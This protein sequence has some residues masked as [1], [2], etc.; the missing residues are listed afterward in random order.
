MADFPR[1]P[2][3]Q[4]LHFGPWGLTGAISRELSEKF[5]R[6]E[7]GA[8]QFADSVPVSVCSQ[9]ERLKSLYLAGLFSYPSFTHAEREAHRI[10]EVALKLRF[11]EHYGNRVPL[12]RKDQERTITVTSFDDVRSLVARRRERLAGHAEFDG[13]LASLLRWARAEGY[14]YGQHNRIRERITSHLRNVLQHSEADHISALPD[15]LRT[16]TLHFQ[17][18]QR[19]WGCDTPGGDAYPGPVPRT[20]WVI[21]R[22]PDLGEVT[23][24]AIEAVPTA[25]RCDRPGGLFHV[26]LAADRQNLADWR[27]DR[28][29]T[30]APVQALWGPDSWA[31]L[32]DQLA[33]AATEWHG[34]SVTVLDRIFYIQVVGGG[35]A[36]PRSAS[37][38]IALKEERA[39]E[40]WYV[41]RA[42][43]PGLAVHHVVELV[44]SQLRD[45]ED[46]HNPEGPCEHCAAESLLSGAPR[47][48][49]DDI[50]REGSQHALGLE[51]ERSSLQL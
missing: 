15:A 10:L 22:W 6:E 51:A 17:W 46:R 4:T 9:F 49:L 13:S 33:H 32:L 39:G 48:A 35:I 43:S 30:P 5:L 8:L 38:V 31:A 21:G 23:W 24:F 36:P 41:V 34:D 11:L 37:H 12:V 26:V 14:F 40:S 3:P 19:L 20:P 50:L 27:A 1:Q 2:D 29:A 18:I 28:E 25:Q 47:S 7:M 42:D 16:I 45:P 44:S